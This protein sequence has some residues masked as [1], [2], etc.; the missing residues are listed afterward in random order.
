MIGIDFL[1][2]LLDQT[3]VHPVPD[4]PTQITHA[5]RG[6]GVVECHAAEPGM[7]WVSCLSAAKA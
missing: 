4:A 5:N 6:L 3:L 2:A 1:Q 7:L